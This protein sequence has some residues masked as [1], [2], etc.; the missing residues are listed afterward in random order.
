MD[1]PREPNKATQQIDPLPAV[2]PEPGRP[3]VPI[4][5]VE[6]DPPV[7]P[8]PLELPTR[9]AQE[10]IDATAADALATID[11]AGYV[12]DGT[13][14]L[15]ANQ[16]QPQVSSPQVVVDDTRPATLEE[17]LD[18]LLSGDLPPD[19]GVDPLALLEELPNGIPRITYRVCSESET[20]EVSCSL[21]LPLGVPAIADVTG[22]GSP[23]V[24]A[25][26]LPAAALG[27]V[28]G[29]VQELLDVE[30]LLDETET[31]LE[32]LLE[33]MEDPL[34][35]LL[36]PWALLESLRL[37]ELVESL[38]AELSDKL[39]ALLDIIHV[40]LALLQVRLPTSEHAG[41]DLPGHV[42]A[43]YDVPGGNRLSVGYD[44][45]RR[46]TSLSTATLGVF[47]FSPL[48]AIAG[49]Y[50]IQASLV[51][52]GAGEA[53]AVT[54]GLAQ[55]ADTDEGEAINPTVA[56]ARFSPV[57]AVFRTRAEIRPASDG[58]D[59]RAQVDA[60]SNV[61]T[62]LDT[63]VMSNEQAS[64]R[65]VQADVNM[66]P[67]EVSAELTWTPDGDR[68]RLDYDADSVIDDLLF[69]DYTYADPT[70]LTQATQ[71]TAAQV[72]ASV[73]ADLTTTAENTVALDY[74]ASSRLASLDVNYYDAAGEIVLRG[75]LQDMPT[76][77]NLL[78]DPAAGRVLF[79][80]AQ[81]LGQA[82]VAASLHLGDY[83][84]LDG[85]HATLVTD[86]P[87]LGV[88]AQV[89]GMQTVDAFFDG[90][91]R[92]TTVFDPGGQEFN[93]AGNLD[94][95]H[96]A[97]LH[98]SNLPAEASLDVD[99]AAQELQYQASDVVNL[100]EVAYT[101]TAEGPTVLAAV[102]DLPQSVQL[103][104]DLGDRPQLLYEASSEIP[105]LD[106]FASFDH[107]EDLQ[108]Q[109]DHYLSTQVTG[110]PATIDFLIDFPARHL[111][112]QMS[113]QLDSIDAVARFPLEGRDWVAMA[114]LGGAPAEFD[115]DWAGGSVRMRGISGPLQSVDLAA[116]NHPDATAPDGL[117]L[118]AHYREVTG[119]L[120][121][122]VRTQNLSHVEYSETD[123]GQT[124]RLETDT[125]GEP[126]FVDVNV[127][128]AAGGVD[129]I[130]L[131]LLGRI[132][133][134]PSVVNV[135]FADGRL[136]YTADSNVGLSLEARLG[137][138]VALEGLGAPLFDN[139]VG[140][141][142]QTCTTGPGCASDE[143][144]FCLDAGCVGLVG[145][146]NLSGL[147]TEV[148][149]DTADGTVRLTGYEPPDSPLQAFVRLVGLI[150]AVPDLRALAT[151]SGLP[152][153]V[154]FT[155]G[156]VELAG[157]RVDV[158]YTASAPLGNL[159]L[160]ADL[161]TTNETF[162]V[163]RAR[164][165]VDELPSTLAVSGE[166]GSRTAL[167]AHNSAAVAGV[168]LT[169]T[170][171][172]E[173]FLRGSLTDVPADIDAIV[174]VPESHLEG[175]MSAPLGAIELL[176]QNIPFEGDTW[177]AYL[178]LVGIPANFDADWANGGFRF[179][180][181]SGPLGLA[182]AAVT[183]HAGAQ[184]P[185]GSHLAAHFRESNGNLDG[186]ASISDVS[187]AEYASDGD[188]LTVNF[189]AASQTIALD[190]DVVL[191]AGGADDTRFGVRGTIGPIPSE[192]SLTS[193]NGVI[194]Y[195]SDRS[196]DAE[197]QLWL[198]KVAAL[199]GLDAPRV[200]DGRTIDNGISLA[201]SG[202]DEGSAG[203]ADEG[204]FCMEGDCFGVTGIV[205][206]QGLPSDVTIDVAA[207]RYSFT[208][209]DPVV[210]ELN[211][212]VAD[213][214]F[215]PDPVT[216]ARALVTLTGL[217]QGIDFTLGP[218]NTD[219]TIEIGWQSD[220]ESAG[221]LDVHADAAGVP[222][223]GDVNAEAVIDPIPGELSFEG[224]FG[225]QSD[226]TVDNSTAI[227]E[228]RVVATGTFQGNPA[229]AGI[230]FTDVPAQFDITTDISGV[231]LTVPNFS[232]SSEDSTLDG[233]FGVDG[234][235]AV[236]TG[237][238]T[239]TLSTTWFRFT[240][241]GGDFDA[242]LDGEQALHITSV[243]V[244]PR[245]ELHT[246]LA[247]EGIA[248][249]NVDETL[250]EVPGGLADGRLKGHYGFDDS[251]IGDL[252]FV[253]TDLADLRVRPAAI[254]G[255]PGGGDL[256]RELGWLFPGFDQGAYGTVN[257]G[258][259]EVDLRPD[260]DLSFVIDPAVGG[261]I[262]IVRLQVGPSDFLVFHLYD[263][264]LRTIL[265]VQI[266]LPPV[267]PSPIPI[268]LCLALDARPSRLASQSNGIVIDSQNGDQMVS[269]LDVGD[270]LPN[271]GVDLLAYF[272]SPYAN[273]ELSPNVPGPF[274]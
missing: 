29:A 42:W 206:V 159:R 232:Y 6:P 107:I 89:G 65:Y 176:A 44:G 63:I 253:I 85:D 166:L 242:A 9:P 220:V 59:Q 184:A 205:D 62:H 23:D 230:E 210:D 39:E 24:L 46:G 32:D 34:W 239:A 130:Q 207:D 73:E 268:P 250:F 158:G 170:S 224:E 139:G 13:P 127:L 129:D 30:S 122:A 45:F 208:G 229:S 96:Q 10:L 144:P 254:S 41:E 71:A 50:D 195:T 79:D 31:R 187:L 257:L 113:D 152:S 226:I 60:S 17:L 216:R 169:V 162:P 87:A 267:P 191:A 262:E 200:V 21:T 100:A 112:G 189:N 142:A 27:D 67:T 273:P 266:V 181:L 269:F 120:D 172:S 249:V 19:L 106:F 192:L 134:L 259:D 203:C 54:A 111:Q 114:D 237:P 140:L 151:L 118:A 128:L 194:T 64:D 177:G 248:D 121:A 104:Y 2:D 199:E 161:R 84:P 1:V 156:P 82:T 214:V 227:D 115:A 274:C 215:V 43:V 256:P 180:G 244:T 3:D 240:D 108:P 61:Q 16:L 193:E 173:G 153:P 223:F 7:R 241:L 83:A 40:G 165:T 53:M 231:G 252:S 217:P 66:L 272:V 155:V 261:D 109:Q 124:F 221:R 25:D 72:P 157:S 145:T 58:E 167:G 88:S 69:A 270:Q 233:L 228:L 146:V 12:Q 86:D 33:L 148:A 92:L 76:S 37:E 14:N 117:R 77:L 196:L 147:P 260:I 190:G 264:N 243:P 271:L 171:D 93:G 141:V 81:A 48:D 90:H 247:V 175:Q 26:L 70:T 20:K 186:S 219:D 238:V 75:G 168:G 8:E 251:S 150:D 202:C 182:E 52:A 11:T 123:E 136:V 164:A 105:R 265:E 15:D 143:T 245:I 149:V 28:T 5:P 49:Q 51:Q 185:A 119:D 183:N 222:I 116:A 255:L 154:D 197:L 80:G 246:G 263:Q 102:H 163:V 225:A 201:D 68:A 234:Q 18:A 55:V 22:D 133:N 103:T 95:V 160:D 179:R 138:V 4:S 131:A 211:I 94:G 36:N 38:T 126:L 56:S 91:P 198:G 101:N 132:D 218:I 57:P 74:T 110:L 188:D 235:F 204:P 97:E 137:K 47:T 35:L 125:Q 174:D 258:V 135:N 209:Y 213:E 78:A 236:E 98:I 99:T 178:N 212:Y